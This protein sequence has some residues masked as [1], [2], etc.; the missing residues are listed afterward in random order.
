MRSRHARQ[1]RRRTA[2]ATQSSRGKIAHGT[3]DNNT[4]LTLVAHF[5]YTDIAHHQPAR[6]LPT[7]SRLRWRQAR[8]R[9]PPST[10]TRGRRVPGPIL[11]APPYVTLVS[12]RSGHDHSARRTYLARAKRRIELFVQRSH[13]HKLR[14]VLPIRQ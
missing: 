6:W 5:V 10:S 4:E 3:V 12:S 13:V 9:F 2:H 8:Q 7:A 1:R 11:P 14:P